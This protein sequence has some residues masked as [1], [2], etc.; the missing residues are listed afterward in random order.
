[1]LATGIIL[2]IAQGCGMSLQMLFFGDM[3]DFFVD[4]DEVKNLLN[5]VNWTISQ[6]TQE[7]ALQNVEILG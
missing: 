2:A 4:D 5:K 7:Q 1:M 3:V 6:Y